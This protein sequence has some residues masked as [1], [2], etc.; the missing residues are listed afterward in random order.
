MTTLFLTAIDLEELTG[1]KVGHYQASWL[2][3]RG[4]PYELSSSGKPRVLRAYVEKRFGL[5]SAQ[6]LTQTEPDFSSWGK[7]A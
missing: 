4:Y 7:A 1:Y 2:K 6:P 3:E 5:A